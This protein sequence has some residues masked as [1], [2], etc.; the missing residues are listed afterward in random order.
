[1]IANQ[2][3]CLISTN[4]YIHHVLV[5]ASAIVERRMKCSFRLTRTK[6]EMREG[7]DD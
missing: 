5:D 7:G 4:F 3:K 6:I 2:V 1:M